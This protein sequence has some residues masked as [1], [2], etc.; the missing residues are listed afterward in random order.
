M[1]ISN[2]A[3]CPSTVWVVAATWTRKWPW[4]PALMIA[5]QHPQRL[6]VRPRDIAAPAP[7]LTRLGVRLRQARQARGEQRARGLDVGGADVEPGDLP[8]PARQR[9]F[10]LR[11]GELAGLGG[12]VAGRRDIGDERAQID[13][14]LLVER[15][16]RRL[17]VER[18]QH[19]PRHR[20]DH[21]RRPPPTTRTA[22]WRS[23][24]R[25]GASCQAPDQRR[26]S[27]RGVGAPPWR[28]C[29]APGSS[30]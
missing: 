16:L 28:S 22:G 12:I 9:Q 15:R 24:W 23:N 17:A 14:E 3:T 6:V 13:A 5:L 27:W 21:A 1:S 7:V 29:A 11:L 4:S 10:E 8:V 19:Q 26:S 25:R 2:C 20:Q 18:G 30:T